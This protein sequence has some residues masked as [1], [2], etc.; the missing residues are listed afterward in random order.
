MFQKSFT[1]SMNST[2]TYPFTL[3]KLRPPTA[4]QTTSRPC[5]F[6]RVTVCP[7]GKL[8]AQRMTAPL[9]KTMTVLL[10][11]LNGWVGPPA[12]GDKLLMVTP[13]S[14]HTGLERVDWPGLLSEFLEGAPGLPGLFDSR[15]VL[16]VSVIA[17]G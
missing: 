11:S 2:S 3:G 6:E 14:R 7:I 1:G 9:S 8:F 5:G 10:S 4:R 17:F 16:I 12:S 13:T 15:E